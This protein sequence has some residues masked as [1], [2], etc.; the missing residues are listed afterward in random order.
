MKKIAFLVHRYGEDIVGG[1]E[2]Y[3]KDVAEHLCSEFDVT[4]FTTTSVDYISWKNHYKEGLEVLNGVKVRRY[5]V[6]H[7]REEAIFSDS[8]NKVLA[9]IQNNRPTT[10]E[11]DEEWIENE[12]P[13]CPD[14]IEDIKKLK[15]KFDLFVVVTYIYYVAVK[16]IPEIA[17]K[18]MFIPTAHDEPWINMSMF[19][20]IFTAPKYFG[21][22]T[23]AEKELVRAKFNN[24]FI[25][26]V[27]L[28]TGIELPII[29][30]TIEIKKKFGIEGD[31]IVYVGRL[32]AAKGC[33]EL[34]DYF[35]KY[36]NINKDSD[37]KLVLVGK[38]DLD[39]PERADIIKTGFVSDYE[40]YCI[41]KDAFLM[42]TPS[43]YES[44]CIALLEGMAL[45]VP[46]VA[47]EK[48]EVLKQHCIK[49]CAGLYYSNELE[50]LKV[51]DYFRQHNEIYEQMSE[52][53]KAY[54][55]SNYTW[56]CVRKKYYDVIER[57]TEKK[58]TNNIVANLYKVILESGDIVEPVFDSAITVVTAADDNYANY[59][60]ITI[61]SIIRNSNNEDKYDILVFTNN[62]SD[63]SIRKIEYIYKDNDNISIRFV[64]V[65]NIFNNLNINIANN[66]KIITYYRL[67]IQS[68]LRKYKKVIYM[69][70]D[71]LVNANLKELWD[72]DIEGYYLAGTFDPL[73]AA[74]Q[75]YDSGMQV[76]FE[77]I[78]VS[79]VGKYLQ[80]GIIIMNIEELRKKFEDYYLLQMACSKKYML[81]DQDILNIY[82][83]DKI[84]YI[85]QAWDVLNM[86][87]DGWNLVNSYLPEDLK[88]K[89]L[90]AAR[91]PKS[92]H[93]VEQSFPFKG[94]GRRFGKLYWEYV[95]GTIFYDELLELY[96][97]KPLNELCKREKKQGS[98]S[99]YTNKIK[100][101][102]FNESAF[103]SNIKINGEIIGENVNKLTVHKGD[104][105]SGPN[106]FW[107][108]GLHKVNII[109]D[110]KPESPINIVVCAGAE[111][112]I[113]KEDN[114]S[115]IKKSIILVTE[116]RFAD[117]E[118]II[119]NFSCDINIKTI[120]IV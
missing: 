67:L 17:E 26:H 51:I 69:D 20:K 13:F 114:I 98:L 116:R 120:E 52:N 102:L 68:V 112:I 97:N 109:F 106:V 75:N 11:E 70:S 57:I 46:V 78:G 66:Y 24:S 40:K 105:L 21:F 27:I 14:M 4:V 118:V 39:I 55:K 117:V 100:R 50:F 22:L 2:G 6:L 34:C 36:K 86:S 32:D 64:Y 61:E 111:N 92:I 56:E 108:K 76:Y 90:E 95:Y 7:E 82:C 60:G 28:G 45:G 31:Y 94:D 53:G 119:R 65:D 19:K 8:C 73:I 85:D 110:R 30:D 10:D 3:T 63:S 77:S 18:C 43:Y 25:P 74:W 16:A 48:C 33:G 84:K 1:A 41:I 79:S 42:S 104:S 91:N 88:T 35:I 37:I 59:V 89:V 71:V 12:G 101:L 47:N 58:D 23:D 38:G 15:D 81:A 9:A 80:A 54:I 87:D 113:I 115:D 49:S 107:D 44:L 96:N 62:M 5:N 72:I 103:N 83:A 93:F 99:R 29:G